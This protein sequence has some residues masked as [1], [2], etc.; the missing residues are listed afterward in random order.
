MLYHIKLVQLH[1]LSKPPPHKK[2][3]KKKN[4]APPKFLCTLNHDIIVSFNQSFS[5]DFSKSSTTPISSKCPPISLFLSCNHGL[6]ELGGMI[7]SL[8]TV[9]Y[10]IIGCDK[11]IGEL[12]RSNRLGNLILFGLL[13]ELSFGVLV[14]CE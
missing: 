6:C 9:F 10:Q 12:T 1:I 3:K 8:E 2:K 4:I 11:R 5:L 13:V 14:L 7:V